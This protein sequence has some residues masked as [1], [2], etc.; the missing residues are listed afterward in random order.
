MKSDTALRP[1]RALDLVAIGNPVLDV[2]VRCS[3][4]PMWDDKNLGH[5]AEQ[6]AGGSEAN[7]ACAASRLG[8]RTALFGNIGQG[9]AAGFLAKELRRFGVHDV[10]LRR[11]RADTCATAVIFVSDA[12]ERAITYVPMRKQPDRWADLQQMLPRTRCIYTL[13]YDM[14]AFER[15]AAAANAAGTLVAVDVER[16]VASTPLALATLG[17][18]VDILFFNETGF[19]SLT[20]SP[21]SL[22]GAAAFIQTTKATVLVVSLGPRGALAVDRGGQGAMQA[23]YPAEVVD[24]TG[25][26]DTFN[27]AFLVAFLRGDAL[28]TALA[29]ACAAACH[30]IAARGARAGLPTW[31][32]IAALQLVHPPSRNTSRPDAASA[33]D[34]VPTCSF[35]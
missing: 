15:I 6:F 29:H 13:P 2:V 19:S 32:Q 7:V 35:L 18:R 27:A 25:A 24:T 10:F 34:P 9:H 1:T 14:A 11:R 12:G 8:L 33:P 28:K 30:C 21:P 22:A 16:A 23:A 20:G 17:S 31:E 4:L 26:G 3:G 5:S